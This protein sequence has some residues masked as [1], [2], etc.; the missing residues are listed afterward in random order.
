MFQINDTVSYGTQ[1]V[2]TVSA[3]QKINL[4]GKTEEYYILKPIYQTHSTIYVP[5][6]NEALVAKMRRIL[7]REEIS[8]LI[9]IMPDEDTIWIENDTERKEKYQQIISSGNRQKIVQLIKTLYLEQSKRMAAGKRLRQS[10]E[11]LFKRAENLLYSEFAL[12]LDIKPEQ[13]VPFLHE[14]IGIDALTNK[15][16]K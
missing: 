14:Q 10:D 6:A 2:C 16:A 3:I 12:V 1:G 11:Q 8:E 15:K 5:V 9:R 13:V 4:S 7:S